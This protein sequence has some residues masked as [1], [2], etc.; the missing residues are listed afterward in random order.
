MTLYMHR[1]LRRHACGRRLRVLDVGCGDGTQAAQ[2]AGPDLDLYGYDVATDRSAAL[3]RTLARTGALRDDHFLLAPDDRSI[4][5]SDATFDAAYANQVFE[6]VR[7]FEPMV[8][9]CARVLRP[10]GILLAQF[11]L[12][13]C[14]VEGHSRVPFAHWMRPGGARLRYIDL[15]HA[16]GLAAPRQG[17]SRRESAEWWEDYLRHRTYY[18]FHNEIE[19]VGLE[20]FERVDVETDRMIAAKLDLLTAAGAVGARMRACALRRVPARALAAVVTTFLNAAYV[21]R[22]PRPIPAT[23]RA[24]PRTRSWH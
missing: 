14:L 3:R 24:S 1:Q 23:D 7:L 12:A 15:C 20:Y 9:E 21:F 4:P 22:S 6:H 2:L 16:L 17:L 10:E 18:R 5:F 19:Q 13:T 11:P 8:R